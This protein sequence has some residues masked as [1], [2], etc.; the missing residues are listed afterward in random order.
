QVTRA[1]TA[2]QCLDRESLQ[3]LIPL[4]LTRTEVGQK[5]VRLVG[6]SLSGFDHAKAE[7]THN[8]LDLALSDIF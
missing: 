8:Q 2:D 1:H 4:L 7:K 5:P 3:H 6:L